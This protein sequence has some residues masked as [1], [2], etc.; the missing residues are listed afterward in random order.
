MPQFLD[1]INGGFVVYTLADTAIAAIVAKRV[2][3][4]VAPQDTQL[5][6]LIYT[7]ADGEQIVTHS[8]PDD[9]SRMTLHVYAIGVNQPQVNQLAK[10]VR[11]RWLNINHALT[12]GTR[13]LLCNGGIAD[14]GQWFPKDSSDEHMFYKRI[15]LRML[16]SE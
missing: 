3:P 2:Y 15:I 4:D 1:E 5:A 12:A 16:V 6:H 9:C 8:G 7:Q 14:G 13:V 11:D 10:L